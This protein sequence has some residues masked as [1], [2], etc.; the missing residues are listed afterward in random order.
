[1][2]VDHFL[3]TL[4]KEDFELEKVDLY[5]VE[6][7]FKSLVNTTLVEKK[8]DLDSNA[9]IYDVMQETAPEKVLILEVNGV[10]F[11]LPHLNHTPD[12]ARKMN[13]DWHKIAAEEYG[14]PENQAA[15]LNLAI[16]ELSQNLESGEFDVKKAAEM[17]SLLAD[18]IGIF[19]EPQ[20]HH[21]LYVQ[22]QKK[23]DLE[24]RL[25]KID[26]F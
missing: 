4:K 18:S 24:E 17:R 16:H 6:K 13:K 11:K 14:I 23:L 22:Q 20:T 10:Q 2:T 15:V 5:S 21:E 25:A 1:M 3:S 26:S 19:N 7:Q 9:K 8:V 12:G